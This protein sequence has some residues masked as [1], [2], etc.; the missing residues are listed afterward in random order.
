MCAVSIGEARASK[1][2]LLAWAESDKPLYDGTLGEWIYNRSLPKFQIDEIPEF[3]NSLT[4]NVKQKN[5]KTPT[6]FPCCPQQF[7][8]NPIISYA[9]KLKIERMFSQNQ[10][11]KSIIDNFA[12]SKDEAILWIICKSSDDKAIKPYSLAEV[13]YQ[14]DAFVHNNLGSFFQK[15]GAEKQFTLAQGL[16]WTRGETFDELC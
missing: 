13:T 2:R 5:W 15:E 10:Y 14:N 11:S 1:S 6:E 16:E 3:T 9:D 4:Q 7:G 12:I 8:S